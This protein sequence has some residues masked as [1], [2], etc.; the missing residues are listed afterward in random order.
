MELETWGP[1]AWRR[2]CSTSSTYVL[3]AS[4][5]ECLPYRRY[6]LRYKLQN[7]RRPP[8]GPRL[9][10]WVA[11]G[12]V[13]T[14]TAGPALLSPPSGSQLCA[15]K[16]EKSRPSDALELCLQSPDLF[17]PKLLHCTA[18]LSSWPYTKWLRK[19]HFVIRALILLGQPPRSG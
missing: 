1:S 9:A 17:S 13:R 16:S 18:I 8:C 10:G 11:P 6:Q 5:D 12:A 19:S 14:Q 4:G 15:L 3:A 7:P 2:R